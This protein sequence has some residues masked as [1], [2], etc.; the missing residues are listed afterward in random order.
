ME[1]I[2]I[3]TSCWKR[4]PTLPASARSLVRRGQRGRI[5]LA[6]LVLLR[7]IRRMHLRRT[8]W[9]ISPSYS[10]S[11][12]SKVLY[13]IRDATV[14]WFAHPITYLGDGGGTTKCA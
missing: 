14:H 10:M 11:K 13:A 3:V 2:P 7:T 12:L 6:R 8:T 1:R 4:G 5:E 9:L